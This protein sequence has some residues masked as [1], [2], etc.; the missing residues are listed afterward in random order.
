MIKWNRKSFYWIANWKYSGMVSILLVALLVFSFRPKEENTSNQPGRSS[1]TLKDGVEGNSERP[2]F[3]GCENLNLMEIADC[4]SKSL[5]GYVAAHLKYPEEMKKAK[6]EGKVTVGFEI[7]KNGLVANAKI[8]MT[9]N[10]AADQAALDVV[11]SMNDIIGKWTPGTK[12]GIPVNMEMVLPINFLLGS[13]SSASDGDGASVEQPNSPDEPFTFVEHMPTFPGGQAAM[14]EFLSRTIKYPALARANQVQGVVIIQLVVTAYGAIHYAKCV[15]GIGGGCNEEALRAVNAMPDWN[16]GQHEGKN[17]DVMFTLRIKF[18][19][20]SVAPKGE[21]STELSN[22]VKN[23]MAEIQFSPN[24]ATDQLT[25]ELFNGAQSIIIYN[26][27]G[28]LVI[29]KDLT[30]TADKNYQLNISSLP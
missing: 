28:S 12:D 11:N 8:K 1:A 26:A 22:Q 19:L 24:P 20:E 15:R 13:E 16:P 2:I 17:V 9:L 5:N 25:I 10:P 7:T 30:E 23:P 29:K 4:T 6:Q 14:Y 18:S 3:P 27:K 21:D